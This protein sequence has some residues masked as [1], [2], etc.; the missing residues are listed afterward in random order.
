MARTYKFS[1]RL[2]NVKTRR[3]IDNLIPTVRYQSGVGQRTCGKDSLTL[4]RFSRVRLKKKGRK[5]RGLVRLREPKVKLVLYRATHRTRLSYEDSR[6]LGKTVSSS[7][8]NPARGHASREDIHFRVP[9]ALTSTQGS[10]RYFP[11]RIS[12]QV[13]L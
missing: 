1:R 13:R 8:K 6:V 3:V 12:L 9:E 7:I 2:R 4:I 10:P 11:P 5:K